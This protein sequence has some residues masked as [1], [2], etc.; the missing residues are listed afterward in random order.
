MLVS[1]P[2]HARVFHPGEANDALTDPLTGVTL[3]ER[4]DLIG[5]V[6]A[7]L[8]VPFDNGLALQ[9]TIRTQVVREDVSGTLDFYYTIFRGTDVYSISGFKGFSVDADFRLDLG[10]AA[11]GIH[12]S[13]DGDTLDFVFVSSEGPTFVKTNATEFALSGAFELFDENGDPV[14]ATATVYAPAGTA[15]P[16][17]PA[18]LAAPVAFGLAAFARRRLQRRL[19]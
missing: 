11:T 9:G 10:R 17:P 5:S 16:L 19:A 2:A 13:D 8:T 4:P 12:R 3:A 18:V 15:I 1:S 14:P 7:D 6:I